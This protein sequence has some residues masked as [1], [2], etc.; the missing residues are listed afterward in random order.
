MRVRAAVVKDLVAIK[1]LFVDADLSVEDIG[2]RKFPLFHL[3][4]SGGNRVAAVGMERHG[5][6][7]LLRSLV[8]SPS[9]RGQGLGKILVDRLEGNAFDIGVKE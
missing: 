7:G 1:G 6:V 9:A 3:A 5:H 4:E 2:E 8:V